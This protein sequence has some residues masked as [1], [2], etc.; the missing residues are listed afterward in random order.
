ME[1]RQVMSTRRRQG[2]RADRAEYDRLSVPGDD[3]TP[4]H[5]VFPSEQDA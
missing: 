1:P 4:A 2:I 5:V 3:R